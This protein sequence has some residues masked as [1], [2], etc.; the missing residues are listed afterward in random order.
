[1]RCLDTMKTVVLVTVKAW[2]VNYKSECHLENIEYEYPLRIPNVFTE[3]LSLLSDKL[4][5]NSLI[6]IFAWITGIY[7]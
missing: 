2:G 1:M 5:G 6:F 3:K 4:T 7:S